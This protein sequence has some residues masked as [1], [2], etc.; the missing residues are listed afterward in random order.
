MKKKINFIKI[1]E[2]ELEHE[3]EQERNVERPAAMSPAQPYFDEKFKELILC[4][5]LPNI[6]HDLKHRGCLIS[7]HESLAKTRLILDHSSESDAWSNKIFVTKDFTR[8]LLDQSGYC[9][10]YLRPVWWIAYVKEPTTNSYILILLSSYECDRLITTFKQSKESVLCM[11]RPRL[12]KLHDNLLN[13]RNLQVTGMSGIVPHIDVN[14]ECQ[15]NVYSGSMYFKSEIEQD[16]YCS[17][18][19]LIPRPRTEHLDEAF[20]AGIIQPNGFVMP[21]HRAF[22]GD[23]S[24]AVATCKF[25]KNPVDLAIKLIEA[26]H[27]LMRKESHVESILECGFKMEI[28]NVCNGTEHAEK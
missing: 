25:K 23:V 15:L 17:F 16:A 13:Q 1:P 6:L 19:G 18:L 5:A 7:V 22:S 14:D 11:F 12:S 3:Q 4:S 21:E 10:E 8:V 26:Q 9:D 27:H 28:T 24:K 20:K 2:K